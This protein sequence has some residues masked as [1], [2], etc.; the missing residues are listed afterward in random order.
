M[1]GR[2]KTWSLMKVINAAKP[3]LLFL[4]WADR[5]VLE[6]LPLPRSILASHEKAE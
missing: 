4:M 1:D 6:S 2:L 5:E 3:V